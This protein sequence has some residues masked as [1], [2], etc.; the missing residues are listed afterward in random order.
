MTGIMSNYKADVQ[1]FAEL[2][3]TKFKDADCSS[4]FAAVGKP[5]T[6]LNVNGNGVLVR[7]SPLDA[8]S[9][10]VIPGSLHPLSLSLQLFR[11]DKP[12]L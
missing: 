7:G 8:A 1:T 3:S 6:R 4:A 10:R 11:S 5:T 9:Q 2:I 12:L